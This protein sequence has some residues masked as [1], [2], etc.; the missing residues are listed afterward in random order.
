MT[1][2]GAAALQDGGTSVSVELKTVNNRYFKLSLRL[3]DGYSAYEP[4]IESLL[5]RTI[6]RGTVTAVVRIQRERNAADYRIC[7]AVVQ[8]YFEQLLD[9]ADKLG[10]TGQTPQLDRLLTLPGVIET[11][12]GNTIEE[13]ESYWTLIETALRQAL[14]ALQTMR[15]TEGETMAKD[16]LSNIKIL[17]ECAGSV[18]ETAPQIAP[19]YRQ[20]LKE[21][22]ESV[23]SEQNLTLNDADL[24]RETALFADRCD[25][26]EEIV[27]FKS[28]LEQFTAFLNT[29]E[30]SGRKLDFLTQELLRETNTMGAKAND[31]RITKQVIEMK[32]VIEKIREMV[33][34]AE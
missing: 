31:A 3:T 9:V 33:Q 29:K 17:R 18:E 28:H 11:A 23:M 14:D 2:F 6:E 12:S 20:R 10:Q 21:R 19:L 22:I 15:K 30:S 13:S 1:G 25:I 8:S 16:L 7:A 32:N 27:R 26:S 34:N 5:R 4:K 24:L